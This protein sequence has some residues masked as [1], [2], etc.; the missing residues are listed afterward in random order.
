MKKIDPKALR[1]LRK[2]KHW[3]MEELSKRAKVGKRRLVELE[4]TTSE[5]HEMRDGNF[6][7]LCRALNATAGQ[8]SGEEPI[9]EALPSHYV[10]LR[11]KITTVAQMNYDLISAQ[12]GVHSDQ[13]VQLAPL[14]FAI[15][16]EDSFKWRREQLELRKQILELEEKLQETVYA[17]HIIG[18][19]AATP[20]AIIKHEEDAINRREVFTKPLEARNALLRDEEVIGDTFFSSFD[21]LSDHSLTDRFT[22]F[23]AAK[24]KSSPDAF[25][26][27]L[28]GINVSPIGT[29]RNILDHE[30]W[31]ISAQELFDQ[32]TE[33]DDDSITALV[34]IA[35]LTGVVRL[36]DAD[37]ENMKSP[38]RLKAWLF[39]KL[40]DTDVASMVA[41]ITPEVIRRELSPDDDKIM[42][43]DELGFPVVF[44]YAKGLSAPQIWGKQNSSDEGGH[45]NASS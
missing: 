25:R 16:V 13:I 8:L 21:E 20:L 17:D 35:L 18:Q 41:K 2:K 27:D 9:T 44:E 15:L 19:Y 38:S 4:K 7:D 33:G 1:Q 39:E 24:L 29:A 37:P 32:A 36:K 10:T 42:G 28:P 11:S 23:M 26:A 45:Q 14:M 12:Y 30:I 34:R 5:F 43:L 3:S 22:D 40:Q 6:S 31:Y